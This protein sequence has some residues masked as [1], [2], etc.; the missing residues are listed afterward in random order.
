VASLRFILGDQLS[1][2]ISSLKGLEKGDIVLMGEVHDETSYVRHHKKKIALIFSAMR[3]FAKELEEKGIK[4]DYIRLD[5]E[6]YD[7]QSFTE[8]LD[9]ALQRHKVDQ[10]II[11]EP[12]EWRILQ[13]IEDW[14]ERFDQDIII[15]EDTRFLA[16][17]SEFEQWAEGRK[18]LRMEYFYREMR[19]KTGLL[20]DGDEPEGGQ[21]NY[22]KS[23]RKSLPDDITIPERPVFKPDNITQDVLE[24]VKGRFDNHFGTLEP[25]EFPVTADQAR[26]ALDFFIDNCLT[27]FGD[28]QDAMASDEP[29]LFHSLVSMSLNCGLLVPQEVCERAEQAYRKGKAP[30]NA[31]EGFI[32]QILGWR[33]YMRGLYW[34]KM[35]D[36]KNTNALQAKRPLPEFYWTGETDMHCMQQA[37]TA[38]RDHAYAHHIQRLMITGNFALLAGIDPEEINEWYLIVYADAFEWVQLPN[39]HGMSQYADNGIIA[40]KPYV[41]SGN[42]IHKMSNYCEN[43]CYNVNEKEGEKAC[44]FNYLY[45]NFLIKNEDKLRANQRMSLIYGS[46]DKMDKTKRQAMVESAERFLKQI[47]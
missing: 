7:N 24:L 26:Q 46:L 35:P 45:W 37:I 14:K 47:S 20:M 11:T 12:G 6:R 38:T 5:D 41:S 31:V 36:Y 40:S 21:W 13:M 9:K 27:G 8:I 17:L 32:R 25:F 10:V 1:H 44:P 4:V 3:H 22:D 42:Y 39:T 18:A 29:F 2:T 33:E 16:T 43:C 34:L 30:L 19:R 15:R 23:N 28:Y